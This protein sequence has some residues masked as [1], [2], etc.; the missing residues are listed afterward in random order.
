MFVKNLYISYK[1]GW[2]IS[3]IRVEGRGKE[4]GTKDFVPLG[5]NKEILR[6]NLFL[7]HSMVN[8]Q[9]YT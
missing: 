3:Y 7:V 6:K 5:N 1:I 9:K 4:S 8:E 2:N